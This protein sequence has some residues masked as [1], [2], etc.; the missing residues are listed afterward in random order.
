VTGL[1]VGGAVAG[2]LATERIDWTDC[3]KCS[4]WGTGCRQILTGL[5]VGGAVTEVLATERL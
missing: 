4:N 2:V 1:T 3:R 5:T